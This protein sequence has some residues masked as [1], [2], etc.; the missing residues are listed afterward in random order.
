MDG[1]NV[2]QKMKHSKSLLIFFVCI[3]VCILLTLLAPIVPRNL[4]E[5]VWDTD[6]FTIIDQRL[7][8][9][10]AVIEHEVT[11]SGEFPPD[12]YNLI[13]IHGTNEIR[14][15]LFGTSHFGVS[16]KDTIA[17]GGLVPAALP[18]LEYDHKAKTARITP[19]NLEPFLNWLKMTNNRICLA[20]DNGQAEQDAPSNH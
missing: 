6:K 17:Y 4:P 7:K 20:Y 14:D 13:A 12:P 8:E 19:A 9:A 18:F 3:V 1:L 16:T 11:S 5:D 10:A 15:S 2:L